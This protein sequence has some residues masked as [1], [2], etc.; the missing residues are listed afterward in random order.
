MNNYLTHI[1]RTIVKLGGLATLI[2]FLNSLSNLAKSS[3]NKN[4][5]KDRVALC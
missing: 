5:Y 4:N 2:H 3:P 1:T